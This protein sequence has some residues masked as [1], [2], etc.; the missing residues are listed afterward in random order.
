MSEINHLNNRIT[1]ALHDDAK[2]L[3]GLSEV[4]EETWERFDFG[5]SS[6]EVPIIK[7]MNLSDYLVAT[8]FYLFFRAGCP[9]DWCIQHISVGE[10]VIFGGYNRVAFYY[11]LNTEPYWYAHSHC[12]EK[13]LDVMA[14]EFPWV[15]FPARGAD[16]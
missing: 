3:D 10:A 7:G 4:D 11:R 14:L 16:E 5:F 12:S 1:A 8:S 6:S 15:V 9:D 2:S 13:F